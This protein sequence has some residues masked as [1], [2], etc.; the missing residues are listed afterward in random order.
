MIAK[1]PKPPLDNE[2]L[3]RQVRFDEKVNRACDNGENN[4]DHKI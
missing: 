3:R 4:D 1:F 2:K